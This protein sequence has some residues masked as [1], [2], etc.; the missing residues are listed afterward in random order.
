MYQQNNAILNSLFT[1]L[2]T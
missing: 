2:A 1:A